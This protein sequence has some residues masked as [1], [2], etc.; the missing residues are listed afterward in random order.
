[1]IGV[2]NWKR[3]TNTLNLSFGIKVFTHSRKTVS[4]CDISE[5]SIKLSAWNRNRFSC[6]IA[7]LIVWLFF[8][9]FIFSF[10]SLT[11]KAIHFVHLIVRIIR[12]VPPSIVWHSQDS[13]SVIDFE[14]LFFVSHLENY[15]IRSFHGSE[16]KQVLQ[17]QSMR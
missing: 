3:L 12:E 17:D 1:M 14:L 4:G 15:S 9:L 5:G 11:C 2:G 13:L 6:L 7:F 16:I 8:G 10:I